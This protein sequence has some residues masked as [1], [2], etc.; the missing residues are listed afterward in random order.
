MKPSA[1]AVLGLPC[2]EGHERQAPRAAVAS[3]RT[4]LGM[5]DHG[6][7]LGWISAE[8]TTGKQDIG[9]RQP[10]KVSEAATGARQSA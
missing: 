9:C 5:R 6:L 8:D 2:L 10:P 4:A 7:E 3:R 1:C